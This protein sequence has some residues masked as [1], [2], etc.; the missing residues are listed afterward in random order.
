MEGNKVSRMLQDDTLLCF[1]DS[2]Q[3][4]AQGGVCLMCHSLTDPCN[5][6]I[7]ESLHGGKQVPGSVAG[8]G[9]VVAGSQILEGL[10]VLL[11]C[12]GQDW[13]VVH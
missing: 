12:Q 2:M 1:A 4:G 7:Q 13:N 3:V 8:V 6:D 9:Q 5:H 11:R 10:F